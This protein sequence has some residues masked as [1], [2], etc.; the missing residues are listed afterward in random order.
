MGRAERFALAHRP[1]LGRLLLGAAVALPAAC[2]AA[3]LALRDGG[4]RGPAG[5]RF[6]ALYVAPMLLAAPLWARLRLGAL[7]RLPMRARALDVAVLLLSAA[8]LTGPWLPFSGHML[9]L[10]YSAAVTPSR[11][12]RLL[13]LLLLAE[14]TA[15]KLLVW[16]DARSW[17][18][19]LA[20]GLAAAAVAAAG[21]ARASRPPT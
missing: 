20:L 13:A 7:E 18:L 12:Y 14:T 1:R 3:A 9:F 16:G 6:L 2:L 21:G 4:A 19:G 15:F 5:A 8:R 10:T 11:P 17:G